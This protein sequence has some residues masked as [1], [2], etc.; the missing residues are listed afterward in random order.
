LNQV[1]WQ[2]DEAKLM[3]KYMGRPKLLIRKNN[4]I[5]YSF[6]KQPLA[7]LVIKPALAS[8]KINNPFWKKSEL[9]KF[10]SS[11]NNAV[12]LEILKTLLVHNIDYGEK[13]VHD[14]LFDEK[15]NSVMI[16][17]NFLDFLF[18]NESFTFDENI[19]VKYYHEKVIFTKNKMAQKLYQITLDDKNYQKD[20]AAY[21]RFCVGRVDEILLAKGYYNQHL[22]DKLDQ[23]I[24]WSLIDYRLFYRL[25]NEVLTMNEKAIKQLREM[26][27][28][29]KS[30]L[31]KKR[32]DSLLQ[33]VDKG[34]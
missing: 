23:I 26:R 6:E 31:I 21:N 9:L 33:I 1:K 14:F 15:A 4:H 2:S 13:F 11:A 8:I 32:I 28:S 22:R 34:Y 3:Q 19:K 5:F 30:F 10:S 27:D 18:T 17:R 24:T 29:S 7:S 25:R 12:K 20:R 16:D